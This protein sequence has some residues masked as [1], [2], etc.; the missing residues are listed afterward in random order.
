[1]ILRLATSTAIH[2]AGGVVFGVF[3]PTSD[4]S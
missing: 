4:I 2:T 3:G 1:M